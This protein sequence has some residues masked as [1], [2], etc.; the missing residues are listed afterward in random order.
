MV[1]PANVY[2]SLVGGTDYLDS[3]AVQVE[4]SDATTYLE[5]RTLPTAN[6]FDRP[7]MRL[8]T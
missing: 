2:D 6:Y 1:V 5:G 7:L 4:G 8:P 3:S